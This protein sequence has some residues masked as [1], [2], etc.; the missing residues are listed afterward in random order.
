MAM[1][2]GHVNFLNITRE[3]QI[4]RYMKPLN[5]GFRASFGLPPIFKIGINNFLSTMMFGES[6]LFL[7]SSSIATSQAK[8]QG[9]QMSQ[10]RPR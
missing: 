3:F 1:A 9:Y 6:R 7:R 2:K 8:H 10:P 4:Q 5:G